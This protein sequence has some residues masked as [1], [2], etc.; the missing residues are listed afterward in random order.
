MHL[1]LEAIRNL[2]IRIMAPALSESNHPH[3]GRT[4]ASNCSY[5]CWRCMKPAVAKRRRVSRDGAQRRHRA[6]A[7]R[8]AR[9]RRS[10]T[11]RRSDGATVAGF[12]ASGVT[13][14]SK[15]RRRQH[16]SMS[17]LAAIGVAFKSATATIARERPRHAATVMPAA[18]ARRAGFTVI[19]TCWSSHTS[20]CI[21][22]SSERFWS[23]ERATCDTFRCVMPVIVA[24][25]V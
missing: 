14:R 9:W 4:K 24:A 18:C 6:R 23:L 3:S 8:Y 1:E 19:S 22:R 17:G 5:A 12:I 7:R 11:R 20:A 16:R 21:R 2:R 15:S 25:A 10:S 13:E